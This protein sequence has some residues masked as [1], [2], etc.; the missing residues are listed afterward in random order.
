M[1]SGRLV[2]SLRVVNMRYWPISED[3][4]KITSP[5]E[6]AVFPVARRKVQHVHEHG[7]WISDKRQAWESISPIVHLD[8]RTRRISCGKYDIEILLSHL[9]HFSFLSFPL[10][11]LPC[12]WECLQSLSE[13]VF[14]RFFG[15]SRFVNRE[16]C[17][18]IRNINFVYRRSTRESRISSENCSRIR[19]MNLVQR[20]STR[21]SRISFAT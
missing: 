10:V 15:C 13:S 1:Y 4:G 19:N 11:V 8:A 2:A 9:S 20:R 6:N 16:H 14:W 12:S 5:F 18:S 3:A 7:L 17:S 21:E